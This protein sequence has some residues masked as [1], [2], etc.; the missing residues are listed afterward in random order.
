MEISLKADL[1]EITKALTAIQRDYVPRALP[2]AMN[3]TGRQMESAG[4]KL[5]AKKMGVRQSSVRRR[6]IRTLARKATPTFRLDAYGSKV[7]IA[8]FAGTRQVKRGRVIEKFTYT[9][10]GKRRTVTA[11]GRGGVSSSAFGK[12]RIYPGTFLNKAGTTAF[13]RVGKARLP[14]RPIWGP[15]IR[16]EFERNRPQIEE[17][18]RKRFR[19]NM[20]DALR[21]ASKG[22][23]R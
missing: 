9:Q 17:V 13:K 12:R 3:R 18:A 20:I 15:G 23:I 21:A 16:R 2:T 19:P 10:I 7:N 11:R 8:S 1:S 6:I 4:V 22:F 14:I 5:V